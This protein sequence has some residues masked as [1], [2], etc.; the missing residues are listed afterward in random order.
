MPRDKVSKRLDK[1][2]TEERGWV[3]EPGFSPLMGRLPWGVWDGDE[4]ET[5]DDLR[6]PKSIE[7]YDMMRNDSQCWGLYLGATAPIQRYVWFIEP[8]QSIR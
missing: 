1:P 2:P 7:T 4:S 5:A 8:N 6:W 3:W